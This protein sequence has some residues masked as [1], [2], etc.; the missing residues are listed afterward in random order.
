MLRLTPFF[1]LIGCGSPHHLQYDHGRASAQA[2]GT[3]GRLDR[4][5]VADDAYPLQGIEAW[6][7]RNR[8]LEQSSDKESGKAEYVKDTSVD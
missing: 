7:M 2:F 4:P 5:E 1:A 6:E 3:Q 8:V